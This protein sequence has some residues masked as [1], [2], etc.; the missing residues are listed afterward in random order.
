MTALYTRLA[1]PREVFWSIV[2]SVLA[3]IGA[4]VVTYH[5]LGLAFPATSSS[6]W[7]APAGAAEHQRCATAPPASSVPSCAP[8]V[9]AL[10]RSAGH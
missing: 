8:I 2:I 3:G 4:F 9:P 5:A 7:V 10:S 6:A 1:R